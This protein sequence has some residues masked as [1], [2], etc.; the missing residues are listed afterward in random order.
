MHQLIM[1]GKVLYWGTSEWSAKEIM[2]AHDFSA[3][4]NLIGPQMEQ[5]Q[6]NLLHRERVERVDRRVALRGRGALVQRRQRRA[7]DL[8]TLLNRN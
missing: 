5:P 2:A 3:K 6:Y 8:D 7:R 4:H 1:A